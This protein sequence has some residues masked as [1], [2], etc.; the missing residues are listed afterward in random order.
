[1][2]SLI[3]GTTLDGVWQA[4]VVVPKFSAQGTWTLTDIL[5][6]D[7][8]NNAKNYLTVEL[9]DAGFPSTFE[10]TQPGPT[11]T[12]M[13]TTS[14]TSTTTTT[15]E[16]TSTTSTTTTTMETTSTTSSTATTTTTLP[17]PVAC[18][19]SPLGTCVTP[20]K[21]TFQ[22]REQ[23][24]GKEKLNVGLKKLAP[25]TFQA[26]FGD[27]VAG[28]TSYAVCV[29]D[30]GGTLVAEMQ[31][32]QAGQICGTKACWSAISDKGYKYTEKSASADGITKITG[33]G[34]DPEKG[35]IQATGQN[36]ISKGQTALPTGV[37]AALMGDTQVT[38]E[39]LTS[40]ASCFGATFPTVT[41]ADGLEF[42]AVLP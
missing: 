25:A 39:I 7:Q 5:L 11:T 9:V 6:F 3:S 24:V 19:A 14:T 16:T 20:A 36:N 26:D 23:T 18:G 33:T 13:E 27:P 10:N 17:P 32:N 31:V 1:M 4:N 41:K 42:K 2:F 35:Q 30:Q 37:A 29:Y 8:V 22:V 21:A 40:D 28:A 15:M 38:V 12:T 34:G